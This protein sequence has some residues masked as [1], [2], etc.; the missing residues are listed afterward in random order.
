MLFIV[1]RW[2][3]DQIEPEFEYRIWRQL[4]GA[5]SASPADI[6]L[7]FVPRLLRQ[8]NHQYDTMGA[9]L[10]AIGEA[11]R[12][13]LEPTGKKT[14]AQIPSP[15]GDIAIIVGNTAHSNL[16]YSQPEERYA[17]KTPGSTPLYGFDAA[18]VALAIRYGQ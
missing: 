18:A 14:V 6:R 8:Y 3:S 15:V 5:F 4:K 9:A 2:E 13:F 17:I 1:V 7:I 16:P 10:I 11:E 12:V